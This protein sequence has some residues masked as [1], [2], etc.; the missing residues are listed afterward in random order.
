MKQFAF[1]AFLFL[2]ASPILLVR[3]CLRLVRLV[4]FWRTAYSTEVACVFCHSPI[5]LLGTWRCGCGY[6]YEGHLLRHCPICRSLPRVARCVSCG[7][8]RLL[9]EAL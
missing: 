9:P 8:S 7:A 1:D 2:L 4:K 3:S 6:Q 5:S